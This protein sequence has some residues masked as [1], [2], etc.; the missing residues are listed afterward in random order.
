MKKGIVIGIIDENGF[1]Q[2]NRVYFRGGCSPTSR[3]GNPKMLTIRRYEK[4]WTSISTK[5][6]R[7]RQGNPKSL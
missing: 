7:I 3:A 1:E 4:K 6:N 2:E 5:E